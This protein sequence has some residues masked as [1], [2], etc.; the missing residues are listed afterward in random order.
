VEFQNSMKVHKTA[1]Q[2]SVVYSRG[3]LPYA[4]FGTGEKSHK[5]K[6]AIGKYLANA[7]FGSFYFI[8]AIGL[9]RF[10][11]LFISLVRFFDQK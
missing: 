1:D 4:T 7:I 2:D 8:T 3:S 6:I 11:G 5:P 10:F 9:M